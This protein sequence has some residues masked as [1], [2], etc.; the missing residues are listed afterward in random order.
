METKFISAWRVSK[1]KW[2]LLILQAI[3][4]LVACGIR[5]FRVDII[6][7]G[8]LV[9][10]VCKHPLYATH[11]FYHGRLPKT[12][13]MSWMQQAHYTLVPSL[14]LE[15]F[16]L[17]AVD[18]LAFGIPVVGE[19]KW[20]LTPLIIDD[21]LDMYD[22]SSLTH[23]MKWCIQDASQ[24]TLLYGNLQKKALH[25]ASTYTTEK[26]LDIFWQLSKNCKS[27]FLVSDYAKDIGWLENLLFE[28]QRLLEKSGVGVRYWGKTKLVTGRR[29][30]SDLLVSWC[31]VVAACRLY[32]E[33]KKQS[34]DLI[35]LHSIQRRIGW[36]WL[37]II[38]CSKKTPVR[39][40]YHDF[41]LFHP[42][43]SCVYHESDLKK[44]KTF[45]WYCAE[46]RRVLWN[47]KRWLGWIVLVA[48]KYFYTVRL[49]YWLRKSVDI[50]LVPSAYLLDYVRHRLGKWYAVEV[51]P[52]FVSHA[53][54]V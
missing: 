33:L 20:G 3:E 31:N 29:R 16:G 37:R 13:T 5:N 40:M 22:Q 12:K 4:Q 49:W 38:W 6:G 34:Y 45:T 11:V 32:Q 8:D 21:H 51:F 46:G 30:K 17:T 1:E 14:F 54:D 23:C 35:W 2:I 43:P 27:C 10:T 7:S 9:E 48:A 47:I 50:H 26:W 36:L 39:C 24:G 52:H 19:K 41:G 28:M 18:S 53:R 44:A 25:I 42:F 15:T